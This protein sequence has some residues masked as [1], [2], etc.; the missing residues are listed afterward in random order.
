[1]RFSVDRDEAARGASEA[2]GE[3]E[4]PP[5]EP[6]VALKG[7]SF[8]VT[9]GADG[10]LI[11]AG[12]LAESLGGMATDTPEGPWAIDVPIRR[13]APQFT[14]DDARRLADRANTIGRSALTVTAGGKRTTVPAPKVR[15][16]LRTAPV[17]GRLELQADIEA[18]LKDVT[19]AVG[20]VG[21]EPTEATFKVNGDKVDV[22]PGKPGM[23]CCA[24]DT[25]TR[26][27]EA[28]LAGKTSVTLDLVEDP[29]KLGEEGVAKLGV[30]EKVATFTTRH[31]GGQPRV[32][33]IHRAADALRGAIVEPGA[34]FSL[35]QRLGQRTE[36]KGYVNAGVIN[37][38]VFE[39][40]VGGGISQLTTTL[41]NAA[42]FAGLDFKTY[43]AH[44]IYIDRYPYGREAT[45]S[46]PAPDLSF[47]NQSP[48]GVLIWT[49][50]DDT[51][52]TVSM[53]STK[54]VTADQTGQTKEPSG[55]CTKVRTERTR[56]YVKDGRRDQS[57]VTA[58]YQPEEGTLCDGTKV[59]KTTTTTAPPAPAPPPPPPPAPAAGAQA[60]VS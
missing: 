13:V 57:Y 33:N 8:V 48:H 34:T 43:Q 51:S 5:T 14:A 60:P 25:G 29:A 40:S 9:A 19:A 4:R 20:K 53:Y 39:E 6:G 45:I 26:V 7:D 3:A 49:S 41:F 38:G 10:E 16:W 52:I 21:T 35:N 2:A 1:M 23:K 17:D 54:W 56:T 11:D 31:P 42:F 55:L 47:R 32:A 36:A 28:L 27:A 50:Y 58:T 46:W 30:K 24:P 15:A 59:Q 12:A 22:T 44:T 18:V 37:R